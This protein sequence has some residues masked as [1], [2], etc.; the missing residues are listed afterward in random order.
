VT[1]RAENKDR[2]GETERHKTPFSPRK[3]RSI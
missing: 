2:E 1:G 3:R